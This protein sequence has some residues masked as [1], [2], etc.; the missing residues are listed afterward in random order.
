MVKK[1]LVPVDGSEFAARA[2]DFAA[3]LAAKYDAE[4]VL[5]HVLRRMGSASV[6][7]EL[8][9]YA[10][11]EHVEV[12]ERDL[13]QGLA[14]KILGEAAGRAR[15]AGVGKVSEVTEIG[16][17]AHA[18]VSYAKENGVDLIAMG[19]RGLGD[20]SGMLV[21]SISHKVL[22]LCACPCVMVK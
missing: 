12:R 7:E 21:G 14:D 11:L 16:D 19:S 6:P 22:H 1:V 3:D 17:P 10:S 4:M 20:L 13:L 18:I 9:S 8:R 5:I 15:Q 2:A